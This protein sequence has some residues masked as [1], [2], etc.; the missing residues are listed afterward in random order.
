MTSHRRRRSFLQHTLL[1]SAVG[2]LSVLALAPV[3]AAPVQAKSPWAGGTRAYETLT[4]R[5]QGSE[6]AVTL[7]ELADALGYLAPL[8]LDWVG[9]TI[10]GPQDIQSA[11]TGQ[12][13]FGGAFNGA[14]VNLIAAG[15]P[16]KAVISYYGTDDKTFEGFWVRNGSPIKSAKDLIGK[17]VG[18]NTFGGQAEFILRE[19]LH[20]QGLSQEQIGQVTL[21]VLPPV[22]TEQA[23]REQRIDVATLSGALQDL[24][25]ARG[26]IR[27]LFTDYGLFGPLSDGTY[28]MRAN[29]IKNNPNT[30]RKFVSAIARAIR[31]EQTT[32]RDQVLAEFTTIIK[33]R[34]RHENIASLK[35][36]KS[37]GVSTPGGVIR[38]SEFQ[39][40]VDWLVRN[41]KLKP[42]KLT[43][44]QLFTNGFNPYAT[45]PLKNG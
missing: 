4:L 37:S 10:S 11:A 27:L 29:F 18:M 32:P 39:I 40:W 35:F 12:I 41:G 26:G 6:G 5:Y 7:P 42:G 3:T 22:S 14:I 33:G 2:M 43:L 21:V 30:T 17:K 34:A 9:N 15:A 20:R 25:R 45:A 36:W 28:V 13:D 23:L 31:W 24:A 16:I 1:L 44:G 38:D 8:K 19:W